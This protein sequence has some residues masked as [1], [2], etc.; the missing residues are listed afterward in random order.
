MTNALTDALDASLASGDPAAIAL[1]LNKA[2][3]FLTE[4][5]LAEFRT[6]LKRLSQATSLT[7]P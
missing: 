2:R 1:A 6:H 4:E 5:K 3:P 7:H